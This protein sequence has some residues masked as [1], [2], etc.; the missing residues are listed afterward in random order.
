MFRIKVWTNGAPAEERE[1]H[2]SEIRVGRDPVNDLVL[3]HPSVS[4]FHCRVIALGGKAIVE[5]L[6][7]RNG[8]TLAGQSVVRLTPMRPGDRLTIG[9]YQVEVWVASAQ[10]HSGARWVEQQ[11]RTQ[12]APQ[13]PTLRTPTLA[14][15]LP[16]GALRQPAG[17]SSWDV[18][19]IPEGTGKEQAKAAYWELVAQY[20]PDK[21]AHLG[22]DLRALA[23]ERTRQLNEAWQSLEPQLR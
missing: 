21:C 5:D 23:E 18:L 8:T 16:P 15:E 7:S 3:E 13:R 10:A 6:D 19:G 1:L 17:P 4:R 14:F 11:L 9:A 22:P 20:H 12:R 2:R